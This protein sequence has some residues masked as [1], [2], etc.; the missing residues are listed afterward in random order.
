MDHLTHLSL[1]TTNEGISQF[2]ELPR[3]IRGMIYDYIWTAIGAIN[4]CYG[5]RVY[6]ITYRT[7][8]WESIR[9]LTTPSGNA[10]WLL[11][12]KQIMHEGLLQLRR[13]ATWHIDWI[14]YLSRL[15]NPKSPKKSRITK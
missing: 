4:L 7:S 1:L 9:G 8:H 11:T 13:E 3:E 12:N 5:N 6:T 10:V 2:L 14:N 15:S